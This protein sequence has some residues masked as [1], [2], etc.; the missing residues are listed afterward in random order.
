MKR[1][2]EDQLGLAMEEWIAYLA[3]RHS[4]GGEDATGV[5]TRF[6]FDATPTTLDGT[7]LM[8]LCPQAHNLTPMSRTSSSTP[9]CFS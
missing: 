5:K 8:S 4:I 2:F 9:T 1:Y 7:S 6:D 3:D